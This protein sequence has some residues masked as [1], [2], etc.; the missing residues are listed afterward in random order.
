MISAMGAGMPVCDQKRYVPCPAAARTW[1]ITGFDLNQSR[2]S[3]AGV[4][5]PHCLATGVR[6][7][8]EKMETLLFVVLG[9]LVLG[10]G[11]AASGLVLTGVIAV[12]R[13]VRPLPRLAPIA[14]DTDVVNG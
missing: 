6:V 14:L 2:L 12:A 9:L 8:G 10:S 5:F 13:A 1:I 7:T 4:A 11:L 3:Y